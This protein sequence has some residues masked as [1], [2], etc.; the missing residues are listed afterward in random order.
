M[1]LPD[2]KFTL[3]KVVTLGAMIQYLISLPRPFNEFIDGASLFADLPGFISPS[4]I[5]G[6]NL[7]PDLLLN[8]HAKCLYI[9]ELTVGYE[10]NLA[11]N[12]T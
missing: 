12:N 2:A 8:V 1:L 11:N 7:R 9:L 4:V 3:A 10:T 5:I 6:D